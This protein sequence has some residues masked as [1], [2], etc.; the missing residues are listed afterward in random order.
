MDPDN[1][2]LIGEFEVEDSGLDRDGSDFE[3]LDDG[4][5]PIPESSDVA[6]LIASDALLLNEEYIALGGEGGIDFDILVSTGGSSPHGI[7]S[8][9]S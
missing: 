3:A 6:T 7:S 1:D 4:L 2:F 9:D 8:W 5:A